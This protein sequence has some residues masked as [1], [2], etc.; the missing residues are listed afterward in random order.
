[1]SMRRTYEYDMN[2]PG[3]DGA[4]LKRTRCQ[5]GIRSFGRGPVNERSPC[6]RSRSRSSALPVLVP[7]TE[8]EVGQGRERDSNPLFL[9][10]MYI[11]ERE[12]K[13]REA[14]ADSLGTNGLGIGSPNLCLAPF[15]DDIYVRTVH[16]REGV[17]LYFCTH[18]SQFPTPIRR[19]NEMR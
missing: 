17:R 4:G 6:S 2:M 16:S 1:M 7:E 5:I 11:L 10:C 14:E 19:E 13:G 18:Y 9:I 15:G 3:C 8:T 12:R